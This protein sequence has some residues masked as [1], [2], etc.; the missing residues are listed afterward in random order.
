MAEIVM[1]AHDEEEYGRSADGRRTLWI[2]TTWLTGTLDDGT[3]VELSS[4]AQVGTPYL[5]LAVVTP[6]GHRRTEI[7]DMG[8][9]ALAWAERVAAETTKAG[10]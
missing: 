3:T 1:H 6:D 8:D 5:H 2:R 9:V 4:G 7:V 10:A